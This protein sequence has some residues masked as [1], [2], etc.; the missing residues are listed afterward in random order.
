MSK[1]RPLHNNFPLTALND[2]FVMC[3]A[4]IMGSS[5][6]TTNSAS[7]S[8]QDMQG[9]GAESQQ[10]GLLNINKKTPRY[11]QPSA[12]WVARCTIW[13]SCYLMISITPPYPKNAHPSAKPQRKQVCWGP[14]LSNPSET[15]WW[16]VHTCVGNF[17]NGSN[18]RDLWRRLKNLRWR[19]SVKQLACG[20]CSGCV[21]VGEGMDGWEPVGCYVYNNFIIFSSNIVVTV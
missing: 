7:M 3:I 9:Q 16:L 20:C 8:S 4:T 14:A 5:K 12:R 11:N 18:W 2:D 1:I 15:P 21:G 17:K 6:S 19:Q 10:S 13:T